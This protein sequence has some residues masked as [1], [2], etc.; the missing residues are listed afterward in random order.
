MSVRAV[1]PLAGDDRCLVAFAIGR[2]TGSA[3]LRN[4]IRRRLRAALGEL[5]AAG[6]VP[7]GAVV[8]SAGATAAT[9]P[10]P[11]LRDDLARALARAAERA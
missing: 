11:S 3:V 7:A 4:R 8:V 9:A 1:A 10:F 2:R 5:A 6:A